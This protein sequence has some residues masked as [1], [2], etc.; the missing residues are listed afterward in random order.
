M[1]AAYAPRRDLVS[2]VRRRLT[3]HDAARPATLAFEQPMLSITFDDFPA[4]AANA[5]AR[6]LERHGA[7][8]TYYA[9]AG[10]AG[11][12]GP[13]G[14][15]YSA[16][17]IVRLVDAGHEIGCHTSSHA[18]CARRDVFSTLED[19]AHN[20][21]ALLRMGAP[22]PR[23][24]AFPYG[25]TSGALKRNLPPRFMSARGIL[26]GLNVGHTDLSQLRAY[27]LFGPDGMRRV[28]DALKKAAKR[29]AWVIGFTHDV[30]DAP[31]AWGTRADEL[32][33]LLQEAHQLGFVVLPVTAALER[34]LA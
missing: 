9:A 2:K 1:T 12:E 27:P 15:G 33:A 14:A 30:S 10:M 20:R 24:H 25:E 7:R 21:D 26:P 31:S 29:K 13:C 22:S 32:D 11:A 4:T 28:F 34:R 19:L 6:L 18:D 8:G 3:Q 17:D 16:D 23:A 5:G